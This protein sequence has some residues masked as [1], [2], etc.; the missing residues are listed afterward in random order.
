MQQLSKIEQRSNTARNIVKA[1][2]LCMS[3]LLGELEYH[4]LGVAQI[5]FTS[6]NWCK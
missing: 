3:Y 4:F 1:L 6:I 5:P 2:L